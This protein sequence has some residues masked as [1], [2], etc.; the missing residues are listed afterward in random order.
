MI[1]TTN[2]IKFSIY[3]RK[4]LTAGLIILSVLELTSCSIT[5]DLPQNNADAAVAN[6]LFDYEYSE[7]YTSYLVRDNGFVDV[8]FAQ[9]IPTDLYNEI[10][11]KLNN[12]PDIKGV[13]A[14]T[15]GSYCARF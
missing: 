7:E 3:V 6:I 4:L 2:I 15:T 14:G 9:N 12:H 13:L 10:V 5:S 11:S 8:T 1:M